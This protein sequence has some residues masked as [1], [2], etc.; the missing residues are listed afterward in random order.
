[1]KTIL[2]FILP[3]VLIIAPSVCYQNLLISL[4]NKKKERVHL[5]WT[6][7][8]MVYLWMVFSVAG[9]GSIWDIIDSG[10]IIKAINSANINLIPFR[11]EGVFTYSMNIIMFMPLGFLIPFIWKN[12]R[13]LLKIV[14]VAFGLSIFIEFAQIP[15]N[16][17]TDIDDLIM[18]V[19]G[20]TAGY[21]IW[22]VVGRYFLKKTA[23]CRTNAIS[24][25]E[26]VIYIL[27]GCIFNF[28]FY[29]L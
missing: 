15:T 21:I 10:G 3:L 11:S 28:I 18:N 17:V 4:K 12:Y 19:V 5:L 25:N 27:L 13:E 2:L 23:I 6:Y 29:I 1:M 22:R 16:R 7:I 9:I 14:L 24:N 20:A 8:M 26:P